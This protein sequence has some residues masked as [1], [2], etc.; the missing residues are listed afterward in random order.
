[1]KEGQPESQL[2]KAWQGLLRGRI[3]LIARLE[4][5]ELDALEPLYTRVL[6]LLPPL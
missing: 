2:D 3:Q 5:E 1:V 4:R 6:E